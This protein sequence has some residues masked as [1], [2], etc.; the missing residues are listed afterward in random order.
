MESASNG[1]SARAAKPG[2]LVDG[3]LARLL[4]VDGRQDS[5]VG[6]IAVEVARD[7]IEERVGPGADLN[8]FELARRFGTSRTP[9][10]EALLVL[11]KE[12]MVEIP[13]RRRP[14]AASFSKETIRE[15]YELRGEL[16]ALVAARVVERADDEE[17]GTLDACLEAMRAAAAVSGDAYFWQVV[18]FQE[19]A[20]LLCGNGT[21]K[22]TIDG[23][24]L[25]VMQLRHLGMSRAWRIERSLADHERLMLA[26][27]ERDA[28]LAAALNR[29]MA[30][31]A[32]AG[33]MTLF[34]GSELLGRTS[35]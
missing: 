26:L 27:H 16:Y 5:L 13:P 30:T 22:R 7:I 11:E 8:S 15:I 32:L 34:D 2:D 20:C 28:G 3:I 17:L 21:L 10:R 4:G 25:R 9:V 31:N 14:R 33:L 12:G 35:D 6:Q 1:P 19:Q 23:L 24:G 18:L 29:S